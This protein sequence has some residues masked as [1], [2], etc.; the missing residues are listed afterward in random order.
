MRSGDFRPIP[1]NNRAVGVVAGKES[2]PEVLEGE[3]RGWRG[4]FLHMLVMLRRGHLYSRSHGLK[5][6]HSSVLLFAK[7]GEWKTLS[8]VI[9]ELRFLSLYLSRKTVLEKRVRLREEDPG[10]IAAPAFL[11]RP[12]A[13]RVCAAVMKSNLHPGMPS[14]DLH[15]RSQKRR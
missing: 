14:S 7:R 13:E 2:A 9:S 15:S 1:T 8:K 10:S 6:D 3:G 12:Q 4:M 11:H 5:E